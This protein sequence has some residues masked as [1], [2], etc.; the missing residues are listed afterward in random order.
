MTNYIVRERFGI[1]YTDEEREE[2]L[3]H[4][5]SK[6]KYGL[7][8][9][10][11]TEE[12]ETGQATLDGEL[13]TY[14]FEPSKSDFPRGSKT[15]L[16]N[17]GYVVLREDDNSIVIDRREYQRKKNKSNRLLKEALNQDMPEWEAIDRVHE[18]TGI[19]K[20]PKNIRTGNLF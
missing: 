15:F 17:L 13:L 7:V 5:T 19:K 18:L 14:T 6:A 4:L 1:Q 16:G 12:T 10:K 3:K 11:C 8:R 2:T 9:M 20:K